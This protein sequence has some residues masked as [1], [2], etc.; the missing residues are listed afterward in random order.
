MANGREREPRSREGIGSEPRGNWGGVE[1]TRGCAARGSRL[2]RS[3]KELYFKLPNYVFSYHNIDKFHCSLVFQLKEV[4]KGV[5]WWN[6][7][8][9]RD[10]GSWWNVFSSMRTTVC[11]QILIEFYWSIR[12]LNLTSEGYDSPK[13]VGI[14]TLRG[15]ITLSCCECYQV[16]WPPIVNTI[17]RNRPNYQPSWKWGKHGDT[18]IVSWK[19]SEIRLYQIISLTFKICTKY[20]LE[21]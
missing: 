15:V 17:L 14:R 12:T 9:V 10:Y 21:N 6:Q 13:I 8:P 2:R 4:S 18:V 1:L 16:W 7:E 11:C 5:Y 3:S 20:E 19:K